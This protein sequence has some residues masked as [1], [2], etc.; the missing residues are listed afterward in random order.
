VSHS[1]EKKFHSCFLKI[2]ATF[3]NKKAFIHFPLD[4]SSGGG[5]GGIHRLS[6]RNK[7]WFLCSSI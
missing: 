2:L 5:G 7:F 1:N 3:K 4:K 6:K